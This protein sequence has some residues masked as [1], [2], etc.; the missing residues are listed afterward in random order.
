[1]YCGQTGGHRFSAREED[2]GSEPGK[3]GADRRWKHGLAVPL[4]EMRKVVFREMVVSQQFCA[5]MR[6]L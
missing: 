6:S 3:T 4:S 2:G 5:A 1:V